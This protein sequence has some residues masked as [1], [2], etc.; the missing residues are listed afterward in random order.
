MPGYKFTPIKQTATQDLGDAV[1]AFT[2]V[3]T[4]DGTL[5]WIG[6]SF[7]GSITETVT[8]TFNSATGV[9][10]DIVIDSSAL[11]SATNYIF[12]PNNPIVL[13]K[14]DAIDVSVTKATATDTAFLTAFFMEDNT[15]IN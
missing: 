1:L 5:E 13:K 7:D 6:I 8:V 2:Y 4:K 12:R 10:Y 11:S 9:N 3:M 14:G 15:W